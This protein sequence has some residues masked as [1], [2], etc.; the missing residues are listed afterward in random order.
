MLARPDEDLVLV[1]GRPSLTVPPF[2]Q[3]DHA[4]VEYC[5]EYCGGEMFLALDTETG[6]VLPVV[7]YYVFGKVHSE[8]CHRYKIDEVVDRL[9]ETGH[10]GPWDDCGA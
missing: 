9:N 7:M 10:W 3:Y 4:W 5:G 2:D 1:H 8:E 6:K